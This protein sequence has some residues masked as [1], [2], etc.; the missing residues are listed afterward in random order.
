MGV[1]VG[2][3]VG[4]G[5]G[6]GE[7]AVG[8]TAVSS[9]TICTGGGNVRTAVG[10]T[11]PNCPVVPCNNAAAFTGAARVGKMGADGGGALHVC[12]GAGNRAAYRL[13]TARNIS[14]VAHNSTTSPIIGKKNQKRRC[15][16]HGIRP[17]HSQT[18]HYNRSCPEN[19]K[20]PRL[21]IFM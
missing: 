2:A 9:V 13:G 4:S 11:V 15:I 1:V 17:F 3:G 14:G 12:N 5:V 21:F 18:R 10:V 19:L 8:V 20:N 16:I 6:V 7:T